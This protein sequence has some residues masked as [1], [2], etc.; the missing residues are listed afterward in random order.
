MWLKKTSFLAVAFF[1]L[2]RT[3]AQDG[4]LQLYQNGFYIKQYSEVSGLAGNMCGIVFE[5]SRGL[6]WISTAQGVSRFDGRQF[7]NFGTNEGLPS[8]LVRQ[9]CEDSLG[10]IYFGT[11][12][13]VA[14]YTGYNKANGGYFY[15][16]P[17]TKDNGPI[18]GFQAV[19]TSTILFQ[20]A[21]GAVILLRNGK[22][23]EV[24]T[25]SKGQRGPLMYHH[26]YKYYYSS[27]DDTMHVFDA[28]FKNVANIYKPGMEAVDSSGNLHIYYNG[29]KHKIAGK[30]IVYT[31]SMP[32]TVDQV[33]CLDTKDKMVFQ[34]NG[35]I[36]H[37]ADGRSTEILNL[38]GLSL[39]CNTI[40]VTRDGA[41]WIATGG[42]GI[43]RITPLPYRDI[44]VI[45]NYF[46]Y[47][48][49][50]KIVIKNVQENKVLN[51][52]ESISLGQT[53]QAVLLDR[54]NITWFCTREGIYK[55]EPGKQA[56]LYTFPGDIEFWNLNANKVVDAVESSTGDIWFYGFCGV[57]HY[58][59][60]AFKHYDEKSGLKGPG[61][62]IRNLVIDRAGTVVINDVFNRI[63]YALD[64]TLLPL[65]IRGLQDMSRAKFET[66]SK[67]YLWVESGKKLYK[68]TRQSAGDYIIADSIFQDPFKAGPEIKTFNFDRENNC[69]IGYA[70]GKVQ[71]FFADAADRYSYTNSIVYTMD[72]GLAPAAASHYAFSADD[73]GNM[74]IIPPKEGNRKLFLFAV[75]DALAR[76]NMTLPQVSLTDIL[77][78]YEHTDWSSRKYVNGPAG[79]PS[80]IKLRYKDNNIIFHYIGTAGSNPGSVLYQTMLEGYDDKWHTT[81]AT[82]ANYTNLSAGKYTF[83]VKAANA[84]GRWSEIHEYHFTILPPW[85]KTWWATI[86]FILAGIAVITGIFY[87][88]LN[89]IRKNYQLKNLKLSSQLKSSLIALMGHDVMTPLRYI[90]KVSLQLKTHIQTLSK[91]T[92]S[93]TLGEINATANQLHFFGECVIHWIKLQNGTIKPIVEEVDLVALVNELS[94]LHLPLTIEKRNHIVNELPDELYCMQDPTVIKIILHNLLLNANKFTLDGKIRVQATRQN[95]LL[96][97]TIND[98]GKGMDPK[99]VS[100]LNELRPITSS[101]G[102]NMEKGWGMG[103]MVMIDLLLI[104]KGKLQVESKLNEGTTVVITLPDHDP[105]KN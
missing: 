87:I 21:D 64:D 80:F 18:A 92:V 35:S 81:T 22:T 54:N 82:M 9:I 57:I 34:K 37:Y 8:S 39:I 86:L 27:T 48:G 84:N 52:P 36:Y 95:G 103:Y 69:W 12:K 13:G 94:E 59:D 5:D 53:A 40:N 47:L 46:R 15:V 61:I 11:A 71:V 55:K 89:A 104:S 97:L 38:R 102:T 49:H 90:A 43:F 91:Q 93:E 85:Y 1:F 28:Q 83:L 100:L 2:F 74:A 20:G 26:K 4:S 3:L 23:N 16:Y 68:I 105:S 77:I 10:Y 78:N 25:P 24:G 33:G 45:G 17:Q 67:G 32:D 98:N 79:I 73:E 66:D 65:K 51:T 6:L 70:G 76:K 29:I 72:E 19:D 99:K 31:S 101:Q 88:R 62:N 41:I 63:L 50:K 14:R 75:K 58:R 7:V 60:G 96:T 44:P 56:K 30:D 42:G